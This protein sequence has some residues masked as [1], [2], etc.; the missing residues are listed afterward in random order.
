MQEAVCLY[1]IQPVCLVKRRQRGGGGG[2]SE[3]YGGHGLKWGWGLANYTEATVCQTVTTLLPSLSLSLSRWA[4]GVKLWLRLLW[5]VQFLTFC[6]G[7]IHIHTQECVLSRQLRDSLA[8]W[9]CAHR[10]WISWG[11]ACVGSVC[12]SLTS[13]T[14]GGELGW[15]STFRTFTDC[16]SVCLMQDL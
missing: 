9:S 2:G 10:R 1:C 13:G 8:R 14:R 6:R 7:H 16:S 5:G 12:W 11:L 4:V 3:K 15:V